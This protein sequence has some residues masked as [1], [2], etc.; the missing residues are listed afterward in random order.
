MVKSAN[1]P[2]GTGGWTMS[3]NKRRYLREASV[4]YRHLA[5]GEMPEPG[6]TLHRYRAVYKGEVVSNWEGRV[7]V[8]GGRAT[9]LQLL[10]H[11][12]RGCPAWAYGEIL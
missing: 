2:A 9:F 8:L 3:V 4:Y 11:W 6:E 12:N 5:A 10:A 7:A 1:R